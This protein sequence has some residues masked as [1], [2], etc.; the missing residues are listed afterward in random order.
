MGGLLKGGK[1]AEDFLK[2]A[3]LQTSSQDHPKK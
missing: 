3:V 2:S 1:E